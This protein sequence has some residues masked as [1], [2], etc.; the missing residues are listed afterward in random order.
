[1][2]EEKRRAV[3]SVQEGLPCPAG[4]LQLAPVGRRAVP[5]RGALHAQ[6]LILSCSLGLHVGRGLFLLH[7]LQKLFPYHKLHKQLS[8]MTA[9]P[10]DYKLK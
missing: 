9:Q 10:A 2:Q 6:P 5:S 1:M 8:Y 3:L 4:M 7:I